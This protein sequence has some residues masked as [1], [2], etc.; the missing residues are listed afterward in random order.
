M[1][2]YKIVK[3]PTLLPGF[4]S[5]D[6][7][8]YSRLQFCSKLQQKARLHAIT[9][10]SSPL[11]GLTNYGTFVGAQIKAIDSTLVAMCGRPS[12]W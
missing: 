3:K 11:I 12:R 1:L 9:P 4:S 5:H 10:M 2:N 6:S 7:W 8:R